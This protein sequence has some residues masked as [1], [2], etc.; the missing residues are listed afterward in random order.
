[1][2]ADRWD[3][4]ASDKEQTADEPS[5]QIQ[6]RFSDDGEPCQGLVRQVGRKPYQIIAPGAHL[7]LDAFQDLIATHPYCT[8]D[9]RDGLLIRSRKCAL[10][11]RHIQFNQ[12]TATRWLIFD[13]DRSDARFAAEDAYLPPPSVFVGNPTNGHG[14]LAY[15]LQTPV[16][17][18]SASR[19]A[20]LRLAAAVERGLRRRLGADRHYAGLIAKNPLHPDWCVEWLVADPYDLQTLESWLF[21]RDMRFEPRTKAEVGLGRNC[22]LFERLREIAYGEVRHF[23][24]CSNGAGFARRIEDLAFR[25]NDEFVAPLGVSEVRSVARSVARWTWKNFSLDAFSRLQAQ[26]GSRMR[27]ATKDR[28]VIVEKL[29]GDES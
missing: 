14:H 5:P 19:I 2:P 9:P 22:D 21:E 18:H 28:I 4:D 11:H 3:C 13:I 1:M 7:M 24:K 27:R 16:L 8:N 17:K 15:L 26:R 23:K 10:S 6:A 25:L 20:P 29:A 12:P